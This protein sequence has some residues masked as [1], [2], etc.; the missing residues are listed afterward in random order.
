MK[1][2]IIGGGIIGLFSAYYLQKAGHEVTVM[3]R[4]DFSDSCSQGNAGMIVPSHI[5]PLAAPGMVAKGLR[6]MF[7]PTSPFYVRPR[8]NWDLLKWGYLFWKNATAAHVEKSIPVLRDL[9]LW[10]KNLYQDFQ[11]QNHFDFGWQE[12]GLLML[13]QSPSVAHEEQE[14]AAIANRAGIEAAVLSAAEVQALEPDVEV[15][16]LGGVFYKGDAHLSPHLL[17][18]NLKNYL[19]TEGVKFL[20]KTE[21]I[22]FEKDNHKVTAALVA[23]RA[24]ALRSVKTRLAFDEVVI[25]TGAWSPILTQELGFS[26]PLQGGKGYSFMLH[27]VLKNVRVPTI[28]LEARATATPMG[29]SLRFAGT[30]E[31]AGTDL[32]VNMNRVQGI[33]EGVRRFYPHLDFENPKKEGVW[34]GLRPCSPDGLP[35][36]GR[37]PHLKN[38]I[39]ATGHGMM[40]LSLAP[41]TGKLVAE[42]ISGA[43]LSMAINSLRLDRIFQN[44]NS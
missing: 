37:L 30:L 2:G 40:G 13:Y 8:L 27:D 29:S 23:D 5:V 9:S 18:K 20:E 31:I 16:C 4:G 1:I 15:S 17:V 43:P 44:R 32:S 35:Y 36:I 34:S 33:V 21:I 14:M 28:M 26:L 24:V 42:I 11:R 39:V 22:G 12:R 10:S 3:D 7:S 6:W 38:I 41:A 19:D 25:T